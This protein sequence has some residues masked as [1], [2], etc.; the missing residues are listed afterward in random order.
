MKILS[1]D[2]LT[3]Q[4]QVLILRPAYEACFASCSSG[5]CSVENHVF[6][7]IQPDDLK[8]GTGWK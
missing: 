2:Q 1:T 3:T 8:R 6:P 4:H 7:V 5:T